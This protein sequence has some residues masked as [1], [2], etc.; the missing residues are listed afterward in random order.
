MK[1][2]TDREREILDMLAKT[3]NVKLTALR[4]N[5]SRKTVYNTLTRIKKKY[6]AC[7]TFVNQ[8]LAYKRKSILL[9]DLLTP[10]V[11]LKDEELEID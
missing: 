1:L 7:R 8:I 3:G 9:E 5:I 6:L 2:L 10:R 11:K 4:L